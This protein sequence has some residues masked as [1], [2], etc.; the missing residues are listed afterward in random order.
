MKKDVYRKAALERLATVDQLDK[1]MKITSPLSWL[2][3][4]GVT[5]IIIAVLVWSVVG[6]LPSTVTANGIIVSSSTSTNTI[7]A[8]S[9]G[10]V[11]VIAG[12]GQFVN[13][14]DDVARITQ[15]GRTFSSLSNQVGFI[16][17][18]L[19]SDGDAVEQ[20]TE[21]FRVRP[22]L[23][24]D[25][26]HVVVCYVPVSEVGKLKIGMQ[27][28]IVLTAADSST[29][30]HME[31]RVVNVDTWATSNKGIEAVVGTDNTITS[32][33]V[34]DTSVCAVTCE[35]LQAWE[36][37]SVSGYYWSNSKGNE[38]EIND[39]MMCSV[40]IITKVEKPLFKLFT[41]IK[42]IWEGRK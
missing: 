25:Q 40:K 33:F 34:R 17:N 11:E 36:G 18:I 5:A 32:Q 9:S 10:T 2:S 30:G 28:N 23:M 26:K 1:V 6:E 39:K 12:E 38:L 16:T 42:D 29:Y 8:Q 4:L 13:S 31:G 27:A 35:L 7:T 20:G 19:V 41:K 21:L 14:G 37:T 24:N 15:G 22:Y 3:L